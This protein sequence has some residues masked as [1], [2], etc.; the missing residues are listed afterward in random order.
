MQLPALI[1]CQGAMEFVKCYV[2]RE[3]PWCS[4]ARA[5][6]AYWQSN[7]AVKNGQPVLRATDSQ[8][9]L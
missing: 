9:T 2:E 1:N 8:L 4:G 7:D 5:M 6:L 3:L